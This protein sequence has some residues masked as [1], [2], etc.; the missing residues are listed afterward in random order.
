VK[1]EVKVQ[2]ITQ[3]AWNNNKA[4][5]VTLFKKTAAVVA[6]GDVPG[7]VLPENIKNVAFGP[8]PK[9]SSS[10]RLASE[11]Q[12]S[13][14]SFDITNPPTNNE[15]GVE[16]VD[17]ASVKASFFGESNTKAF[18][19][20]LIQEAGSLPQNDPAIVALVNEVSSLTVLSV[21]APPSPNPT[22][23]PTPGPTQD[24]VL[25][26]ANTKTNNAGV[27]AGSVIGGFVGVALMA[28]LYYY[29]LTHTKGAASSASSLGAHGMQ[30]QATAVE[31]KGV[32]NTPVTAQNPIF[33]TNGS[34]A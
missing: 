24:A 13:Q 4:T 6:S 31:M 8:V 32:R 22:P 25:P 14:V 30:S 5:Y 7:S 20:Q 28:G 26:A 15:G 1:A 33:N 11:S 18:A 34:R 12:E 10:R 19:D 9:K 21:S 23:T 3:E 16:V 2:G 17:A 29:A 27:I